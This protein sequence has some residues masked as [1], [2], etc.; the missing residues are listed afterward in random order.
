[1]SFEIRPYPE[2]SWSISR[3][4]V[5]RECPRRYYYNY[6]GG[7]N[8]WLSE[9]S[10]EIKTIYRLKHIK[11]LYL[12][13][14]EF[15][16]EVIRD[17][18]QS[19]AKQQKIP[20][21]Q[22]LIDNIREKLNKAYLDSQKRDK[23]WYNLK[24]LNM[25]HEIY[26]DGSLPSKRVEEI[27]SR[28]KKCVLNFLES[29]SF[30]EIMS[31]CNLVQLIELDIA[32]PSSFLLNNLKIYVSP[33]LIYKLDEKL[34]VVDWKTG[35]EN[36]SDRDQVILYALYANFKYNVPI[37]KIECRIEN[38]LSGKDYRYAVYPSDII[39]LKEHIFNSHQKMQEYLKKPEK[40]EPKETKEF[41]ANPSKLVCGLCNFREVCADKV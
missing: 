19:F 13:F 34:V 38:L 27:K 22:N 4:K 26:Y 11:N 5:F 37:D 21:Q 29:E 24:Y 15:V 39:E 41:V 36:E 23:W 35:V 40:N 10:I 1:M 8:G 12:I 18:I 16:H 30:K 3:D 25:L 33:D 2:W 14:G 9:A 32:E 31:K 28:L 6:Y 7:H 20:I 17:T